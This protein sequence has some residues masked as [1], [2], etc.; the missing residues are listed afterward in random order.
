MDVTEAPEWAG[1]KLPAGRFD[2]TDVPVTEGRTYLGLPSDPLQQGPAEGVPGGCRV[3][4]EEV[5]HGLERNAA[6]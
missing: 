1:G 2:K 5:S 3:S 4:L 6:H